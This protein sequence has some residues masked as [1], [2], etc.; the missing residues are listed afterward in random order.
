[1]VSKPHMK[2]SS[3]KQFVKL[4]QQLAS[5]RADII[6]RLKEVEAALGAS[7]AVL[8]K[9]VTKASVKPRKRVKNELSLKEAIL[10]V[11]T[12][13]ALT[14][15]QILEGVQKIGYQFRT[16]NPANSLNV[17]LYGKKPK[18]KRQDGKFSMA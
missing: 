15:E 12:G 8:P 14:K 1:M 2:R 7:E 4:R 6:A 3:I 9:A 5:E 11:V 18:F 13:K 10:K 17:V 16:K